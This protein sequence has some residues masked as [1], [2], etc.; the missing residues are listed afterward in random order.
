VSHPD[1]PNYGQHLSYDDV[2]ELLKPTE[3]TLNL[4]LEWLQQNSVTP[5]SYSAARDWITVTLPISAAERLLD[6]EYHTFEHV[7][8]NRIVRTPQWSLP[9]HLHEHIETIQ[10]TTSFFRAHA[11]GFDHIVEDVNAVDELT[12]AYQQASDSGRGL[13]ELCNISSATPQC[14]EELY[15]TK[16]YEA[17]AAG[18]NQIGFTNYLGEH[19][20]RTDLSLFL[21]KFRPFAVDVAKTF[22]QLV[23]ADGPGD[24]PLTPEDL[25]EGKS[26]EANLDVQAISGINWGTP[27][28]SYSTGGSPPFNPSNSTS[29]N[30]NEPYLVWV[31]WLQDQESIP[32]VI[33][34]SYGDEE[35]T[36][37][38]SYAERVCKQFAAVGA[39]GT[40]L[41]FSSGDSGVGPYDPAECISNDGKNTTQFLPAFPASVS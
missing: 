22:K 24:T 21:A 13:N 29:E 27:I 38:R 11:Q 33:S 36:V 2:N 17:A 30:T 14:F 15:K 32:Q 35:Q 8:G 6:T 31:N 23:I 37:P 3:E 40:S 26:R 19:P 10:P 28:T 25:E 18:E 16:G 4:V 20:I 5:T 39:R 1:H 7:N 34:T 9:A 12:A 41:I